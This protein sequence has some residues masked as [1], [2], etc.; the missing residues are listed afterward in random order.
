M[1]DASAFPAPCQ[2]TLW[3]RHAGPAWV[4][5]QDVLDQLFAPAAARLCAGMPQRRGPQRVL[6]IGC[7]AGATTLALAAAGHACSGID[8]AAPL[9]DRARQRAAA[10]ALAVDFIEADAQRHRFA[11]GRFEHLVSRFGVMFFDDPAGAFANLRRAACSGASLHAIAWR[12]AAANPFMTAVERAVA[13]LLPGWRPRPDA[14]PGQFGFADPLRVRDWLQTAGWRQIDL[15]P[16]DLRCTM[17]ASAL[18][19]YATRM[20]PLAALLPQLEPAL[21]MRVQAAALAAFAPW[22]TGDAVHLEAACW[23]LRARA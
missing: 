3:N 14:G 8:I 18:P 6:D 2:H 12:E 11:A 21:R 4:A 16:L 23:E 13:P 9:L 15:A 20:G 22:Q 5:L 1:S 10:A 17:P 7:G 19:D